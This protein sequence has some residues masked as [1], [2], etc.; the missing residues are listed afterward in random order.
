MEEPCYSFICP[1]CGHENKIPWRSIHEY[2]VMTNNS[3]LIWFCTKCNG[4]IILEVFP[5]S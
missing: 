4:A 1:Y 2:L 5:F 3:T